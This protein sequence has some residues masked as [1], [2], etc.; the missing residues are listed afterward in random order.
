MKGKLKTKN[1][2]EILKLA[3]TDIVTVFSLEENSFKTFN[4][5]QLEKE[6]FFSLLLKLFPALTP[7]DIESCE[8]YSK[9]YKQETNVLKAALKDVLELAPDKKIMYDFLG[10]N[11]I[12]LTYDQIATKYNISRNDV[13]A[14]FHRS[15][16]RLFWRDAKAMFLSKVGIIKLSKDNCLFLRNVE[17]KYLDKEFHYTAHEALSYKAFM[18]LKRNNILVLEQLA[19]IKKKDL[20]KKTSNFGLVTLKEVENIMS[21]YGISFAQDNVDELEKE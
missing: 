17:D 8:I 20:L 4:V 16:E 11:G 2:T 6:L 13:H 1:I 12:P 14:R 3:T 7:Y 10:I 5:K 15:Q 21:Q 9:L 18:G 19:D